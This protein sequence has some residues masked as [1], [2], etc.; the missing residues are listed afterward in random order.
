MICIPL[1]KQKTSGIE[2]DQGGSSYHAQAPP[3]LETASRDMPPVY[4]QDYTVKGGRSHDA[5]A[6]PHPLDTISSDMYSVYQAYTS[7]IE[8][9]HGGSSHH[10]Q[11]PYPLE[12][13]SSDMP[14]V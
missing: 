9:N 6:P 1:T 12:T 4:M 14:P 8:G 13:V 5:Q 7:G 3:P 2:G 10:A 11:A